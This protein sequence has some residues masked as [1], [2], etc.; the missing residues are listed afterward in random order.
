MTRDAAR[1]ASA[2]TGAVPPQPGRPPTLRTVAR[3]PGLDGAWALLQAQTEALAQLPEVVAGFAGAVRSLGETVQQAR[4]TVQ[5]AREALT[6]LQQLTARVDRI[7]TELDEPLRN[8]R[9]GLERLA[10]VLDDDVV[11]DL[12]DTLRRVQADALPVLRTLADTHEKVAS[13]AGST[14]RL[15]GFVDETSRAFTGLPGAGLLGRRRAAPPPVV[16]VEQ[17]PPPRP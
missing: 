4:E 1:P 12:P 9:P 13:I 7:V 15:L 14:D 10:V 16:V 17:D 8:L 6:Q 11:T 5:Q 3:L 2:R